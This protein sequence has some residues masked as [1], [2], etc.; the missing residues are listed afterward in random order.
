VQAKLVTYKGM[1]LSHTE[2]AQR[3]KLTKQAVSKRL[4]TMPVAEAL[5]DDSERDR[6]W[7]R[8]MKRAKGN[9]EE[10]RRIALYKKLKRERK[11][12]KREAK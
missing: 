8:N 2:W 3:L 9:A 7:H 11:K 10:L 5:A 12:A 4:R 6:L 1:T